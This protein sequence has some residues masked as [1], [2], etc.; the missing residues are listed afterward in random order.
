MMDGGAFEFRARQTP[1]ALAAMDPSFIIDIDVPTVDCCEKYLPPIKFE[2]L[3]RLWDGFGGGVVTTGFSR[4]QLLLVTL[5]AEHRNTQAL[6]IWLT[7]ATSALIAG[8]VNSDP[9]AT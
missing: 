8:G 3:W 6:T 9:K 5:P 2:G 7:H 4:K 1:S